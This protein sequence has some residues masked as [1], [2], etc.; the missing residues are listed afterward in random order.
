MLFAAKPLRVPSARGNTKPVGVPE[1]HRPLTM[2]DKSADLDWGWEQVKK[3]I[4]EFRVP[5]E[6]TQPSPKE[7]FAFLASFIEL[8]AYTSTLYLKDLVDSF[9]KLLAV[10]PSAFHVV[11]FVRASTEL[12]AVV[13]FL[14]KHIGDCFNKRDMNKALE[15][16]RKGIFGNRVL[17]KFAKEDFGV[18]HNLA[19]VEIGSAIA[20]FSHEV[21][22]DD[23]REYEHL[24]ELSHPNGAA[25]LSYAT[26]NSPS[27][28][29][30]HANANLHEWN[31]RQE[32][33][34]STY[35][36]FA[37]VNRLL[38][39]SERIKRGFPGA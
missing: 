5:S 4:E 7:R 14:E 28:A 10:K 29:R 9:E 31:P 20:C 2:N 30:L 19:P 6:L 13:Y 25:L 36:A 32:M 21:L 11:L 38:E 26:I 17:D 15:W 27:F 8:R 22:K 34:T 18:D 35:E 1:M 12:A 39:L 24:S 33:F 3:L 37:Q 16:A 23:K